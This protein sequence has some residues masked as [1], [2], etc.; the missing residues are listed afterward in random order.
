MEIFK[1]LYNSG[2]FVGLASP[3]YNFTP[4]SCSPSSG[5]TPWGWS[6][7]DA[8]RIWRSACALAF[9]LV[10]LSCWP[11]SGPQRTCTWGGIQ[12]RFLHTSDPDSGG[13]VYSLYHDPRTSFRM[14]IV[15]EQVRNDVS[16]V[17]VPIHKMLR[18]LPTALYAVRQEIIEGWQ[19]DILLIVL[20][21]PR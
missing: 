12:C 5:A 8:H 15:Y 4:A 21:L 18:H 19:T 3:I 16:R 20:L 9:L 14:P 13:T 2:N 6:H 17:T 10:S 1:I 7:A 11:W